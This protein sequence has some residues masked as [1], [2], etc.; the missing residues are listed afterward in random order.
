MT[1][2]DTVAWQRALEAINRIEASENASET[3]NET[4]RYFRSLGAQ[5]LLIG[6]VA[7]PVL[8]GKSIDRFGL[9]DWN[10][11][12]AREWIVSDSVAHDP[13]TQ[14]ALKTRRTFD[15]K[16]ARQHASPRGR[17]IMDRGRDFGLSDGIAI[18]VTAGALPLGVVSVGLEDQPSRETVAIMD[19][20]AIHAYTHLLSFLDCDEA[21]PPLQLTA[22]ELDI[23][24][25]SAAGKTSWE[26]GKIY[27]IS[28]STVKTHMRNIIGKLNAANKTHAVTIA[29]RSGQIMP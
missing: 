8:A 15:W 1:N 13:V 12:Y 22:R 11:D 19:V 9:S 2:I 4:R 17:A 3:F 18:P 14:F 7:N 25:F 23:L 28:D 24:T 21:A 5:T 26:I 16:T 27:G 29:L 10:E 20:V 6:R